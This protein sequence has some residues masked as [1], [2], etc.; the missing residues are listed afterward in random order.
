ML[1]ILTKSVQE[2]SRSG[3]IADS[4]INSLEQNVFSKQGMEIVELLREAEKQG[5]SVDDVHIAIMQGA[6]NPIEWLKTQWPHLIE[7]VRILVSTRAKDMDNDNGLT[8]ISTAECKEALR[9][10]KGEVWSAVIKAIQQRQQ[11]QVNVIKASNVLLEV[12][13]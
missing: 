5:F 10:S 9:L 2:S 12:V 6:K 11:Q 7:T 13:I 1:T 3:S 8:C 4:N